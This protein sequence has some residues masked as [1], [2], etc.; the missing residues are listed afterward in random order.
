MSVGPF[1]K[2]GA[3]KKHVLLVCGNSGVADR[4]DR[5]LDSTV[6][7]LSPH[8]CVIGVTPF[9]SQMSDLRGG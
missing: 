5:E 7:V 6:W 1:L 8:L 3:W 4:W 2:V 9:A